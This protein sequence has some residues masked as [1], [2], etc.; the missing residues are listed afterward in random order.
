MAE[1]PGVDGFCYFNAVA[2]YIYYSPSL[3][4]H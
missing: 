1:H 2:M 3:M 4:L